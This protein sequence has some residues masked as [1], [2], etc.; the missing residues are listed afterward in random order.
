MFSACYPRGTWHS[1]FSEQLSKKL[2]A[3]AREGAHIG[4]VVWGELLAFLRLSFLFAC[5]TP[6]GKHSGLMS[7][8]QVLLRLGFQAPVFL[9]TQLGLNRPL[10]SPATCHLSLI[11][12]LQESQKPA[13]C[14]LPSPGGVWRVGG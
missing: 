9:E 13:A 12:Q 5:L 14:A 11:T 7:K 1:W 6:I 2:H 4:C 3:E 8:R 10:S